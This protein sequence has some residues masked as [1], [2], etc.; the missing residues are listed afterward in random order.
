MS[1]SYNSTAI[2]SPYA[3]SYQSNSTDAYLPFLITDFDLS[4]V[5]KT[6]DI[7]DYLRSYNLITLKNRFHLILIRGLI[8]INSKPGLTG[9]VSWHSCCR[10]FV[11]YYRS[12]M[13]IHF[14][15]LWLFR[16]WLCLNSSCAK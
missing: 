12:Q 2:P 1:M 11:K 9:N 3:A 10:T 4:L 7:F 15:C 13:D 5:G 8:L 6:E 16:Y 14:R